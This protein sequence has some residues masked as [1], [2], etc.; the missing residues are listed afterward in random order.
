MTVLQDFQYEIGGVILGAGTPFKIAEIEGLGPAEL[1]T[2]D[3]EPPDEDGTW[4]G[5]D[6]FQGRVIRMDAGIRVIGSPAGVLDQLA[7]LSAIVSDTSV[8]A[9]GGATTDLRMKLPG[10][11]VRVVR[12]RL[13]RVQPTLAQVIHGWAPLDVEFQGADHLFYGE[14]PQSVSIPLGV[15]STGGFTAPVTAPIVV[16]GP[17]PT[18]RPGWVDVDGTASTWPIVTVNGPCSNPVI[19]HVESGRVLAFTGTVGVGEWVEIDTRPTY[20][21]VTR[22]GGGITSL[23]PVSRI[24]QFQLPP[25]RSEIRWSA[26]DPTNTSTLAVTWWPAY[27]AL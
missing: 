26:T 1:R 9:Q 22:S 23:T 24:D 3:V 21:S 17:G 16:G 25:G 20:R 11:D 8:R 6:R 19:T 13:R 2:A 4:L 5:V 27:T 14:T 10:R 12:G 18:A 7:A 15:I